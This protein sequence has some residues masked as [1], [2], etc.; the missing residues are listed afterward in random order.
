MSARQAIGIWAGQPTYPPHSPEL[1]NPTTQFPRYLAVASN[2][3]RLHH[4]QLFSFTIWLPYQRP[5]I[6]ISKFSIIITGAFHL[7]FWLSSMHSISCRVSGLAHTLDDFL[8][9]STLCGRMSHV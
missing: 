9:Q 5:D 4:H 3:A 7:R 8:D 6:R 2:A 1:S